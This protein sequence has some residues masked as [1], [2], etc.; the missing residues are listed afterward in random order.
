MS[1]IG[2]K[3]RFGVYFSRIQGDF[4]K[5]QGIN[6]KGKLFKRQKTRYLCLQRERD[7]KSKFLA[8]Y[9]RT[10]TKNLSPTLTLNSY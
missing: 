8:Y 7:H 4:K 10:N 3:N 6:D 2:F 9:V 5:P 1:H